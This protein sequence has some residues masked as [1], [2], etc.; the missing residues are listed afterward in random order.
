MAMVMMLMRLTKDPSNDRRSSGESLR[1]V[2][3]TAEGGGCDDDD[4]DDDEDDDDVDDGDDNDAHDNK[5]DEDDSNDDEA[6]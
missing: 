3:V 2:P 6:N 5:D 1:A 4:E